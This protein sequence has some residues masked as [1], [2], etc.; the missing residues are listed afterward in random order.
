M[1]ELAQAA[2]N[3]PKDQPP[4]EEPNADDGAENVSRET[5]TEH[6]E[7]FQVIPWPDMRGLEIQVPV[8][9]LE[10][11]NGGLAFTAVENA[12]V[13]MIDI[14]RGQETQD[15]LL[16]VAMGFCSMAVGA[17]HGELVRRVEAGEPVRLTFAL[18]AE[19]G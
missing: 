15:A 12:A 3:A 5:N 11:T 6:E 16:S 7:A 13:G 9:G 8:L 2:A 18:V 1:E 19:E 14:Q 10:P 4:V 17:L